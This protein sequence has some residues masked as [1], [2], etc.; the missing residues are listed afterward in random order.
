MN[1][2]AFNSIY[3]YI[4][5]YSSSLSQIAQTRLS[6]KDS[7]EDPEAKRPVSAL[8]GHHSV[9]FEPSSYGNKYIFSY[10]FKHFNSNIEICIVV[11]TIHD[12]GVYFIVYL[13]K[14]NFFSLSLHPELTVISN[15][16]SFLF[17]HMI[18]VNSSRRFVFCCFFFFF[19]F[20]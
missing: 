15:K 3:R 18:I 9:G 2:L 14:K 11:V 16:R 6:S 5:T 1:F 8:P 17:L 13:S 4:T 20:C 12:I 7:V 19:F 10:T